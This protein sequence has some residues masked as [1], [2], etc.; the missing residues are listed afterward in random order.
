MIET[1]FNQNFSLDEIFDNPQLPIICY[2]NETSTYYEITCIR[3]IN[4]DK[5]I[6]H[7]YITIDITK[8]LTIKKE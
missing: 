2:E 7:P 8:K 4:D 6:N 1:N 3:P 5:N